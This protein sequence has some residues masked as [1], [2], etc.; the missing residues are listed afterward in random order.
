MARRE[1]YYPLI[2]TSAFLTTAILVTFLVYQLREPDRL[3]ADASQD[4]QMA[5]EEGEELYHLNCASCHGEMG[6]G[7][8]GPPLN[9]KSFLE[10]VN[11]NRLFSLIRSGVPSTGMPAWGQIFG[12]PLTDEETRQLVAYIRSWAPG[13]EDQPPVAIVADPV[14][15]VEIFESICAICHGNEGGGTDNAPALNNQQLLN[16]FDDDWFRETIFQGR[17]SKGMPTWGTVL[18]PAQIDN[19]VALLA[20]WR[21]GEEVVSPP[22]GADIDIL[23]S[24]IYASKCAI[25]HGE[26]GEGGLGPALQNNDFTAEQ[27]DQELSDFIFAGRTDSAMPGFESQLNDNEVNALVEFLRILQQ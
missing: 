1:N 4:Q 24:E 23:G 21:S 18:S 20:Q 22:D 26:E 14:M 3:Q 25:C 10:T 11:D 9:S 2:I 12:G 8:I 15:G 7:S 16:S 5:R 6:D 19:V 27:T 17:P 13:V